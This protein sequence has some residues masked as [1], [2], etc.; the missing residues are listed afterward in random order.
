MGRMGVDTGVGV[1]VLIGVGVGWAGGVKLGEGAGL[2]EGV[3][4]M[5]VGDGRGE[6]VL[7]PQ[8]T[9]STERQKTISLKLNGRLVSIYDHCIHDFH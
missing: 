1:E 3:E 6:I 2:A 8:E 4:C 9:K 5:S 7:L